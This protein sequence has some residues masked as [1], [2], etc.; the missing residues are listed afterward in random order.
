MT[1]L[2]YFSARALSLL[3]ALVLVASCSEETSFVEDQKHTVARG[4]LRITIRQR[5]TIEARDP[6]NVQSPGRREPL[7]NQAR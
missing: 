7:R 5:G 6:V 3:G 2:T 1:R 4:D